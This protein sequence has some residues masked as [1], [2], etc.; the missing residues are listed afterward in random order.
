MI[1][2]RVLVKILGPDLWALI[3]LGFLNKG[4]GQKVMIPTDETN[5]T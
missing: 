4:V 1:R 2:I 3:C 5:L